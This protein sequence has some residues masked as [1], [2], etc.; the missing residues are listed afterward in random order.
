MSDTW[1]AII[2]ADGRAVSYGTVVA[3]PLPD[4]FTAR[5]L[6]DDEVATLQAPTGALWD[7]ETEAVVPVESP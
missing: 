4:G 2:D 7:T 1:F 5:P 6:T 3:D